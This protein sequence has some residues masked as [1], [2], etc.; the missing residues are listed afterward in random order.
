MRR[1]GARLGTAATAVYRHIT[2]E[3]E[4][5]RRLSR[6]RD[7]EKVLAD[8]MAAATEVAMDFPRLRERLAGSA[9]AECSAAPT[10]PSSSASARSSTAS[11]R[12]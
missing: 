5:V 1:L 12:S 8:T 10:V 7:P 6:S 11:R 2:T 3:D 4:L 9:A